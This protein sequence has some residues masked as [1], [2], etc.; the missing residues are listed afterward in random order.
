M[1][2]T[3]SPNV[4]HSQ[5]L[6]NRGP[7]Y[8]QPFHHNSNLLQI[9]IALIHTLMRIVFNLNFHGTHLN[10][11]K[12]VAILTLFQCK[13]HLYHSDGPIIMIRQP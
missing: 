12:T 13:D 7:F 5:L 10:A 1:K 4:Y 9:H 6:A 11:K 2:W 3:T 8:W